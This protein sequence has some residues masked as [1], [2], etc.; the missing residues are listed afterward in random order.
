MD[1]TLFVTDTSLAEVARRL[2]QLG[3]DVQ[4]H[5]GARLE[6]LFE[7]AAREGRTV[8]TRSARHPRRWA[9]V[10]V[11]RLDSGDAARS[12]REVAGAFTPSL[13]PLSRCTSC[14]TALRPRS[15]FEAHGEVPGR[16]ARRGGPLSSCPSCGQWFWLGSHT[17]RLR[18]WFEAALG[19]P[20]DWPESPVGPP[21]PLRPKGPEKRVP[22]PPKAPPVSGADNET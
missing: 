20:L 6:E 15:A 8:L 19:R 10:P 2:R 14:N 22:A 9:A 7:I 11:L 17:A 21:G 12:V 3:F 16:V 13:G 4:S 18:E 1:P 5:R